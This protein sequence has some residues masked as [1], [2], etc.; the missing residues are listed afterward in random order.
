MA[1]IVR[2]ILSARHACTPL[3]SF[4]T[5]HSVIRR[6]VPTQI[7]KY[8]F[9]SSPHSFIKRLHDAVQ[10]MKEANPKDFDVSMNN[11]E[12]VV[13]LGAA[14]SYRILTEDGIIQLNSPFSAGHVYEYDELN[15][16]WVSMAD[17]HILSDLF[18]RELTENCKG[19][20]SV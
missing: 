5:K 18:G 8:F 20:F 4:H 19:F 9:S 7:T 17:G 15:D 2:F 12:L 11:G 13:D 1:G 6:N 16:E 14:G 10:D 3:A